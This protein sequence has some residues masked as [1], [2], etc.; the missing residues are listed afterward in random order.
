MLRYLRGSVDYGLQYVGDSEFRPL[1]YI[2]LDWADNV[3]YRKSTSVSCLSFG[4]A[5][6]LCLNRKKTS[7]ALSATK[8]RV[9]RSMWSLS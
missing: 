6:I 1:G 5:M 8:V 2:D 7:V 3:T 4:L 9:Y